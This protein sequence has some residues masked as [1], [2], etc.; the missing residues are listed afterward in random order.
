MGKKT[1]QFVCDQC[2]TYKKENNHWWILDRG[3][4]SLKILPFSKLADIDEG[5]EY[6]FCGESCLF[7]NLSS[8]LEE[9]QSER[10][11]I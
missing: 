5:T 10:K 6:F 9:I 8:V 7:K 4:N 3:G 11:G 2:N 1:T